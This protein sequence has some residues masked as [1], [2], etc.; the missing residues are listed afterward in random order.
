MTKSLAKI[1]EPPNAEIIE[2]VMMEGDLKALTVEQRLNYYK[3]VCET[4]GLNPLTK[5]FDY[6]TL[7]GKLVLYARKDATEQLRKR[8]GISCKVTHREQQETI[9]IVTAQAS[10]PDGRVDESIG[11]VAIVE[12]NKL[13]RK[14]P[15][16]SWNWIDHPRAGQVIPATD[17]ANAVM[18]AETKAK[19]RVTLSICGLGMLDETELD[20]VHQTNEFDQRT[21]AE[22]TERNV[23]EATANATGEPVSPVPSGERNQ[24]GPL[25]ITQDNY[26]ELESH[27]GKAQGNMLGKKVGELPRNMIDWMYSKW[28]EGLGPSASEQDMRLKKAI[29]FAYADLKAQDGKSVASSDVT[30]PGSSPP[31]ATVRSGAAAAPADTFTSAA[32]LDIGTKQASIAWL[33]NQIDDMVMTEEQFCQYASSLAVVGRQGGGV[34]EVL[35]NVKSGVTA[36]SLEELT[37]TQLL[38][39]SENWKVI[40]AAIETLVKPPPPTEKPAKKRGRKK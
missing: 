30:S 33:R 37:D 9:Y 7:D 27:V 32:G 4:L 28:R 11:A 38:V 36:K 1:P 10:L 15:D 16:G 14:N 23:R 26:K 18:K 13:K 6:I 25:V 29:E 2:K 40:R 31:P 35:K 3:S 8:Y 24:L 17:L 34:S 19:R 12:P 39:L 5:P 22:I 21:E 20:T